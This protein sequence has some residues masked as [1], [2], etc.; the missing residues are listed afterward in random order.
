MKQ[1]LILIVPQDVLADVINAIQPLGVTIKR[2]E[3]IV[4]AEAPKRTITR[5]AVP[6]EQQRLGGLITKAL[7]TG[8]CTMEDLRAHIVPHGFSSASASPTVTRLVRQGVAVR[9]VPALGGPAVF[10]IAPKTANGQLAV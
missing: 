6:V 1:S 2:I 8:P 10:R 4:E 5:Q 3:A 9:E 7:E